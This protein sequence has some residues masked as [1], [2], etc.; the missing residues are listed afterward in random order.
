MQAKD[1]VYEYITVCVDDLAFAMHD[2]EDFAKRL[3][4]VHDFKLGTGEIAFH[5]GCDFYRN[6]DEV[7]CMQ[8]RKYIDKMVPGY[9]RMFGA[10]PK[11]LAQSPLEK[12]DHPELDISELMGYEG[13]QQYQSLVCLMQW[14]VS[15]GRFDIATAVMTLS[16]FR[17]FPR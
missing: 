12:G 13:I 9:E 3:Q 5:L 4:D 8:P 7:L 2:P 10:K 17:A 15:L 1:N 16:G 11:T 14:D 6:E